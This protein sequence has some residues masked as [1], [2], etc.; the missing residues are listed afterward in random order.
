MK[1][2]YLFYADNVSVSNNTF[3]AKNNQNE[4][5]MLPRKHI[6]QNLINY[7]KSLDVIDL[8]LIGKI[9]ILAN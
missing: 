3:K 7:S 1:K 9:G 8:K 5:M 4:N 2:S 6:I